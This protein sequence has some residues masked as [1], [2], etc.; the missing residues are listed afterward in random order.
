MF[1]HG[2]LIRSE[3]EQPTNVATS[4]CNRKWGLAAPCCEA[5]EKTR[6]LGRK[7]YFGSRQQRRGGDRTPVQRLTPRPPQMTVG[8]G[9]R[10]FI[11]KGRVLHG[12]RAGSSDSQLETD[13]WL[14]AHCHLDCFRY[15]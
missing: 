7:V 3:V 8:G 13:H 2:V 14:S 12:Q 11:P 9:V 1:E 4:S 6:L 10:A 5:S 15:S